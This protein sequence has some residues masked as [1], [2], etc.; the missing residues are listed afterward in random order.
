MISGCDA[1]AAIDG[2]A[3]LE[4]ARRAREATLKRI[5]A[6]A[7]ASKARWRSAQAREWQVA[8]QGRFMTQL[9]QTVFPLREAIGM[10]EDLRRRG[11]ADAHAQRYDPE[12]PLRPFV[13]GLRGI[14]APVRHAAR[15]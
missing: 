14:W 8:A 2:Q 13:L 7:S 3:R 12:R 10:A 11:Y 1:L 9:G 5:D 6:L 4:A 15:A